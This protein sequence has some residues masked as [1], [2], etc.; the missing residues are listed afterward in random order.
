MGSLLPWG[1]GD[2]RYLIALGGEASAEC[3]I[4]ITSLNEIVDK[5]SFKISLSVAA[6]AEKVCECECE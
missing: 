2:G 5:R 6:V 3:P 4:R 1:I